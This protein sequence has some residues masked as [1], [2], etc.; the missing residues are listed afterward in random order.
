MLFAGLALRQALARNF[1]LH[2]RWAMRL[3]LA[4]SAS[5]FLPAS[6]VFTLPF[7]LDQEAVNGPVLTMLSFAQFVVPLAIY[8]QYRRARDNGGATIRVATASDW[9][10]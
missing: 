8:E 3:Y 4:V 7:G 5:L 9:C 10:C 2:G 1:Q 6:F